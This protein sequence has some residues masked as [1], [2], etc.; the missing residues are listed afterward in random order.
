MKGLLHSRKFMLTAIA[1]VMPTVLVAL[2]KLSAGEYV[3][4]VSGLVGVLVL[5]IAHEDAGTKRPPPGD[6]P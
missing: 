5:A 4:T 1:V 3:A 6:A 2:E